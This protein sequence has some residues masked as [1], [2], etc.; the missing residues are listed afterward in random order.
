MGNKRVDIDIDDVKK[1]IDNNFH[2]FAYLLDNYKD[3]NIYIETVKQQVEH[4]LNQKYT[5]D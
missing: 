4:E 5:N 1:S 2:G 3:K